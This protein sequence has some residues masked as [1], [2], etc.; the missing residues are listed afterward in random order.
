MSYAEP[1]HRCLKRITCC[2]GIKSLRQAK[3]GIKPERRSHPPQRR[4]VDE[5]R[6]AWSSRDM[7]LRPFKGFIISLIYLESKLPAVLGNFPWEAALKPLNYLNAGDQQLSKKTP[8]T[9]VESTLSVVA[10]ECWGRAC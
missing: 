5:L 10:K 8:Q 4:A 9:A 6:R 1:G 3:Y 2:L 7:A